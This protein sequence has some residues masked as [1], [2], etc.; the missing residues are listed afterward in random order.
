[1]SS[2]VRK[3]AQPESMRTQIY[4]SLRLR[5]QGSEFTTDDRLV[6]TEIAKEY[7]TSRDAVKARLAA[8]I[9]DAEAIYF[10]A[11]EGKHET[12]TA[13]GRS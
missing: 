3:I 12:A 9:K 8:F 11:L 4:E 7:G 1:M 5:L 6:D 10:R 2:A 13:T